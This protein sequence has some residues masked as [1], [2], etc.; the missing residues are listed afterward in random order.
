MLRRLCA[1]VVL[2]F[3]A[4]PVLAQDAPTPDQ[5][6]KMYDDALAQLKAA[7]T[8]KNELAKENEKLSAG[9]AELE[10][11]LSQTNAELTVLR[12]QAAQYAEKTFFLRSYYNAWRNFI[13][14]QPALMARWEA[15]LQANTLC[16]PQEDS[17]LIDPDWP[18]SWADP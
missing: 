12:L 3:T 5:L 18:L 7:Q 13:R 8:R 15:F 14:L 1:L 9:I 11:Q 4:L 16:L 6:Q 10:K 2:C 17:Q